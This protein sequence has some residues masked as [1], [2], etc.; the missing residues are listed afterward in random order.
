MAGSAFDEFLDTLDFGDIT[1]PTDEEETRD[2][3]EQ[4]DRFMFLAALF[5]SG[6]VDML[7]GSTRVE[8]QAWHDGAR[9]ALREHE[10]RHRYTD[11]GE[12]GE[13]IYRLTGPQAYIVLV[14]AICAAYRGIDVSA[15]HIAADSVLE[16]YASELDAGR[17]EAWRADQQALAVGEG[18]AMRLMLQASYVYSHLHPDAVLQ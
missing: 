2:A 5:A 9:F 16:M 4:R 15:V 7:D 11:M 6:A 14:K 12:P 1:G 3:L 13:P 10:M 8:Q 17:G 18:T